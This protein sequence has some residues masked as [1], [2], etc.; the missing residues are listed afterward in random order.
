MASLQIA[1]FQYSLCVWTP[2]CQPEKLTL[3]CRCRGESLSAERSLR[4]KFNHLDNSHLQS[5]ILRIT[6]TKEQSGGKDELISMK[7]KKIFSHFPNSYLKLFEAHYLEH[8]LNISV[9]SVVLDCWSL[10]LAQ[11]LGYDLLLQNWVCSSVGKMTMFR[12]RHARWKE[13]VWAFFPFYF[14]FCLFVFGFS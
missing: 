4:D 6:V 13:M 2:S 1:P 10:R 9:V 11:R 8:I 14:F 12:A 5:N 7:R 3:L